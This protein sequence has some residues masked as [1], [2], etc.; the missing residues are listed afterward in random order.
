MIVSKFK[1]TFLLSLD[2]NVIDKKFKRKILLE[3]GVTDA[4]DQFSNG[5]SIEACM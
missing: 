3:K 1:R 5:F 4:I 2:F